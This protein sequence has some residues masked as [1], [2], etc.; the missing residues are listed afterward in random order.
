M[1]NDLLLLGRWLALFTMGFVVTTASLTVLHFKHAYN[2][3]SFQ[4]FFHT[5]NETTLLLPGF[6][7]RPVQPKVAAF[8]WSFGPGGRPK[9]PA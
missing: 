2:L 9:S 1:F 5:A 7:G 3:V 4:D 6:N 8:V